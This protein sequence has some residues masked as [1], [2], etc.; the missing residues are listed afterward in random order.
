MGT[1]DKGIAL[2]ELLSNHPKGLTLTDMSNM[3]GF[4]K[5][6]VHRI[7]VD[8]Y[9]TIKTRAMSILFTGQLAC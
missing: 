1:I 2:I 4:N 8:K 6:T 7:K 3:L 5:S 9:N